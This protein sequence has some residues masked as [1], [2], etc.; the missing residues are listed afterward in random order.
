[1]IS[2]TYFLM[3]IKDNFKLYLISSST[4]ISL[5]EGHNRSV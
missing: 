5:N 1:M 4:L 2:N 3:A